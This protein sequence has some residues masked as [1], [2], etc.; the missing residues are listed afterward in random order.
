[1]KE[2]I[3]TWLQQFWARQGLHK[4]TV[5]VSACVHYGAFRYGRGE[6]NPYE[7]YLVDLLRDGDPQPARRRLWE[8][9]RHYRPRHFGEALGADLRETQALWRYPWSRGQPPPAWVERDEDCPD[10]LT[11]FL[12]RGVSRRRVEQEFE[13]LEKALESIRQHGYQPKRFGSTVLARKLV[14]L[15]GA[16][17]Y[18][19]QDGNHRV[20]ALVALGRREVEVS[21][22]PWLTVREAELSG[23]FQVRCGACSAADARWIFHAYFEGNVRPRT[24][25]SPAPIWE[26]VP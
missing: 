13:W 1:M 21:C 5:Q 10:I 22:P 7:T 9:L 3:N 17:S 6:Y 8:F 2:K 24:V 19:L 20:A 16:Q 12:D 23:W 15:D 26:D 4:E 11:H 18:L 14:R 25:D